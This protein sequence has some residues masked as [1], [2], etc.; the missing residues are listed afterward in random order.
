LMSRAWI[1]WTLVGLVVAVA[2][3]VALW[4]RAGGRGAASCARGRCAPTSGV[5]PM[6]APVSSAQRAAAD[7]AP[8]PT[9][10]DAPISSASPL[11][12][13]TLP[14]SATGAPVALAAALA[15]KPALVN[16]WAYWCAPCAEELPIVADYARRAGSAVTVLTVHSDVDEAAGLA[17]LAALGVHLPGVQ[18]GGMRVRAAVGAPQALPVSVLLRP[19][20]TVASLIVRPFTGVDDIAAT[21]ARVLGVR[22]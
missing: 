14:C 2:L 22:S 11:R 18:D 12:E 20:G 13:V 16:L 4:P 7:L 6:P 3:A 19:D 10:S 8:C 21:V 9:P 15:G 17:R 1:R 5:E